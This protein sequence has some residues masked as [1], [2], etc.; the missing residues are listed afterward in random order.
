M[1][2]GYLVCADTPA[3]ILK[4][5][6][7][8]VQLFFSVRRFGLFACGMREC[9]CSQ[10]HLVSVIICVSKYGL[11]ESRY[12][13][14]AKQNYSTLLLAKMWDCVIIANSSDIVL[15]F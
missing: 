7:V 10:R 6:Y 14:R 12:L 1:H 3:L 11:C 4:I 5:F 9:G 13:V 15:S 2:A 8:Q